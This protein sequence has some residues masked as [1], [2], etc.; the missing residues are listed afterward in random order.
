V[1]VELVVM[2]HPAKDKRGKYK[3]LA[4]GPRLNI[5]C[6]TLNNMAEVFD[7]LLEIHF[8][9][10]VM[11]LRVEVECLAADG[12]DA[13]CS[14]FITASPRSVVSDFRQMLLYAVYEV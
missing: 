12:A 14:H 8:D 6:D 1:Q 9:V 5:F 3:N 11:R 2:R 13:F 4:P 10:N 7:R